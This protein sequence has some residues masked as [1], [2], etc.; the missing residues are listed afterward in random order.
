MMKFRSLNMLTTIIMTTASTILV[1]AIWKS[2][3]KI[4][5][6]PWRT[7]LLLMTWKLLLWIFINFGNYLARAIIGLE[8]LKDCLLIQQIIVLNKGGLLIKPWSSTMYSIQT[9][10]FSKIY[11]SLGLQKTGRK[12]VIIN[13]WSSGTLNKILWFFLDPDLIED[14][15]DDVP[16]D[17]KKN[18]A[19]VLWSTA[20][21]TSNNSLLLQVQVKV[22]IIALLQQ[23]IIIIEK[24]NQQNKM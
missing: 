9:I 6:I 20:F 1:S 16:I 23:S 21:L 5:I 2:V 12:C 11:T 13:C 15:E 24:A 10:Y 4:E 17:S 8:K 18:N 14:K 22:I 3:W 7:P 19:C